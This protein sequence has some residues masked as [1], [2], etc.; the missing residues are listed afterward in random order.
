[1]AFLE[2]LYVSLALTIHMQSKLTT[3]HI[4]NSDTVATRQYKINCILPVIFFPVNLSVSSLLLNSHKT[5]LMR[6]LG[7]VA[8]GVV[9]LLIAN[10]QHIKQK[11]IHLVIQ[12]P[13]NSIYKKIISFAKS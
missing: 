11:Q 7:E 13:N 1:M 12:G 5:N 4:Q 8:D 6:Y 9:T 2:I 10:I 3:F